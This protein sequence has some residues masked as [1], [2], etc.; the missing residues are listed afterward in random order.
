M[1]RGYDNNVPNVGIAADTRTRPT[2]STATPRPIYGASVASE[3]YYCRFGLHPDW[4]T[5]LHDAGLRI[6]GVDAP[7][8]D[9]VRRVT[10]S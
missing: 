10:L 2:P 9:G 1:T 7:A 4:H 3:R 6:A 5:T 8:G